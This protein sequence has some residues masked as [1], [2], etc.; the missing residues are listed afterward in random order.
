MQVSKSFILGS[1]EH[2]E[3]V[4]VLVDHHQPE[5]VEIDASSE[6]I[7]RTWPAVGSPLVTWCEAPVSDR[8][9]YKILD[10]TA[11]DKLPGGGALRLRALQATYVAYAAVLE[12]A[13]DAGAVPPPALVP[14]E[15]LYGAFELAVK[16][17]FVGTHTVDE[18]ALASGVA[19]LDA[20][21]P[22]LVWLARRRLMFVDLRGR[23]IVVDG[24]G[25]YYLV[26][27]DDM[28]VLTEPATAAEALIGAMRADA[29]EKQYTCAL[30]AIGPLEQ[31]IIKCYD[32][33]GAV[34][35]PSEVG[36]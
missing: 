18:R 21:V 2:D 34:S 31:Q 8:L 9:F 25:R 7:W 15:L 33:C 32:G 26:D 12:S 17:P 28:V 24:D 10:C 16:M 36:R 5:Y 11:F 22:A 4:R 1:N 13:R 6:R 29:A 30:D 23:N 14:A 35:P 20:I 3:A 19:V 27:Y